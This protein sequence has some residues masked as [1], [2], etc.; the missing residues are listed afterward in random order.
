[1]TRP[2]TPEDT[3]A[4]GGLF[5]TEGGDFK[6]PETGHIIRKGLL[7]AA[8]GVL[9]VALA[10]V[11]VSRT[12]VGTDAVNDLMHRARLAPLL[13]ALGFM[14]CA[15]FFM[16]LRWRALMPPGHSPPAAGLTAI[17]CSGLLL[18]YAV[19]GPFGEVGA[20]WF[21]HKRYGVPMAPA[22]AS[23]V[24]ARI[25]GLITAAVLAAVVWAF[26]D[27]PV[28]EGYEQVVGIA[29]VL[30]GV[31]GLTLAWLAARPMWWKALTRRLLAPLHGKGALG[32]FTRKLESTVDQLADAL[33]EVATRGWAAYTRAAG[34]ALAGHLVVT[35]GIGIAAWSLGT[36]ASPAGV[37]FT[38]ATT[39]AGAV[40]LFALPGS[41]VGWDAMFF[42]LLVATAGLSAPDAVAMALAVRLQQLIIMG[43]GAVALVWLMGTK[44]DEPLSDR[45]GRTPSDL[46]A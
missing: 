25:V 28:P 36:T 12:E 31:G 44:G 15:F 42:T 8:V 7:S 23:G 27:L 39:T 24:T 40:A 38:Y 17:I 35:V 10:L 43:V 14:S 33:A 26:S 4:S 19:P 18:N 37:V 13:L 32:R 5:S 11:A 34:W 20:A 9:L 46:D 2:D 16:S 21:A 1:M 6:P 41:Q 3:A 45:A 22:L 29:A 30:T